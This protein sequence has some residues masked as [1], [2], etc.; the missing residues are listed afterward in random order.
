MVK[1]LKKVKLLNEVNSL[2]KGF[3][4]K[5][6]LSK[7]ENY[8]FKKS[9]IDK[10]EY[11]AEIAIINF[12][13][14]FKLINPTYIPKKIGKLRILWIGSNKNQDESGLLQALKKIAIVKEFYNKNNTY[15]LW[16][17]DAEKS[18]KVQINKIIECNDISLKD[19]IDFC[20]E[21]GGLDIILYLYLTY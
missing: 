11:K 19:Q 16:Y 7:L 6:K 9:T 13:N 14:N 21:N 18:S 3:L 5:Y 17:G 15:G 4:I 2:I 10:V 20:F 12:K 1:F 8:Y